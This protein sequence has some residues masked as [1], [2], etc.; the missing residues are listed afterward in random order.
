MPPD[1]VSLPS[2]EAEFLAYLGERIRTFR[3]HGDMS[4]REL[5]R[6]TGISE[7][8]IALIEAGRGNISIVLLL[9]IAC[10][11]RCAQSEIV[12]SAD[13]GGNQGW[14]SLFLRPR[15]PTFRP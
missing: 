10:A 6:R 3:E 4:R 9:R 2:S 12:R 1:D 14:D 11:I 15:S 8:Y 7:R 13:Q 5:A